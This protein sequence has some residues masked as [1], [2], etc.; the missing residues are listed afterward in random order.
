[1]KPKSTMI[2]LCG[3]S[4]SGKTLASQKLVEALRSENIV[5]CGFISPAVFEESQ[6][7]AIKVRWLESGEE[8]VLMTPI[9]ETSRLTFGRWQIFPETFEW[10]K[11]KLA[12]LKDC[13][14]FFCDEIGPLEVLEEKGWFNA[15][16]IL[17][18]KKY[19]LNVVTFRPSLR[20][21]FSQ[22]YPDMTIFDLDREDYDNKVT[23]LV[24]ELFGID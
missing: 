15:L 11:K 2:G 9:T 1:M 22:R 18:K 13:Q 3:S 21:F 7:T 5:C 10:I 8:R 17:D 23:K 4:G 16:E 14:T 6:K 12:D 19:E 20:S 24:R